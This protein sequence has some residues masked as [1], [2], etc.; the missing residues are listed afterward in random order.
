MKNM[1][2]VLFVNRSIAWIVLSHTNQNVVN[3]RLQENVLDAKFKCSKR[4]AVISWDVNLNIVKVK[5]T[6]VEFVL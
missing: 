4:K 5:Y 2:D 1:Q 3:K 6:F